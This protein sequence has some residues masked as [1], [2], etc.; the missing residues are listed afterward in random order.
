MAT[1]TSTVRTRCRREAWTGNSLSSVCKVQFTCQDFPAKILWDFESH[2]R[3]RSNLLNPVQ[4]VGPEV[5]AWSHPWRDGRRPPAHRTARPA[6]RAP[7][8]PE[9]ASA[10]AA[11]DVVKAENV[12]GIGDGSR[13]VHGHEASEGHARHA[14]GFE[15]L[16]LGDRGVG[17]I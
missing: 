11:A 3:E 12:G 9:P 7:P 4:T 6:P 14:E 10:G 13:R 16:A 17:A 8:P 1:S 2:E 15:L 5:T